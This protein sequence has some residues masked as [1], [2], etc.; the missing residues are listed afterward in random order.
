MSWNLSDKMNVDFCI[1]ALKKAFSICVPGIINTDQGSQ[2]TSKEWIEFL[3]NHQVKISMDG[4]GCFYD[5]IFIERLW[6]TIKYENF[7]LM[8]YDNIME[9]YNGLE[10]F[11]WHYNNR[12]PHQALN[13][14]TPTE[15]YNSVKI[16]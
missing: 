7:Y 11:F 13:Y 8:A 1:K 3:D 16:K 12:R 14:K 9:V 4:K 5:N 10:N 15:L 6:R 2:F